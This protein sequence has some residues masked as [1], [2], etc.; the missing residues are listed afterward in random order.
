MLFADS[1]DGVVRKF[2]S[3]CV[4]VVQCWRFRDPFWCFCL[5]NDAFCD[6]LSLFEHI[7]ICFDLFGASLAMFAGNLGLLGGILRHFGAS[8]IH[9][10]LLSCFFLGALSI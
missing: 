4:N 3:F 1:F 9:A 5:Q 6:M 8:L 10:G 7:L 2:S